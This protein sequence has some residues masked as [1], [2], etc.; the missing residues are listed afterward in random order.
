MSFARVYSAQVSFL[1]GQI[2]TVEVDLS[3][4]LHSFSIVGL[5]DKAVGESKDRISG[6]IKNSGFVSPKSKNQKIV[7]SLS[8]AGFKKEGPF[9]DLAMALAYLL[10]SGDI[11]FNP[12]NKLFLGELGLDGVLRGIR[13]TLLLLEEAKKFGFEEIYLPVENETESYL[14]KGIKIFPVKNLKEVVA[15]VSGLK[16]KPNVLNDLQNEKE[17]N[18]DEEI[19]KPKIRVDDVDFADIKGQE[20][21]KRG[22]EIASAGKHNVSMI[23]PPGT[24]KTMLAKAFTGILPALLDSEILEVTGIHSVAGILHGEIVLFPPFRTPHHTSSYSSLIGGGSYPKPGEITLAH[25]GVLFLDEFLEFD[26]RAIEALR[27]PLEENFISISRGKGTVI[28]PCNFILITAMNPCPCGNLGQ[29]NFKKCIC[30]AQDIARYKR[31]LSGPVMDRIDLWLSVGNIDFNKDNNLDKFKQE[32]SEEIKK[33]ILEA[34][35]IQIERFKNSER[36]I[37]TNSEMNAKDIEIY[38][39]LS[40]EAEDILRKSAEKLGFSMRSYHR[41]IKVARTIADLDKSDDIKINHIL[42]AIQYKGNS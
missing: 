22:L 31:K 23:G 41:V 17:K 32:S 11:K 25:R 2:V 18:K 24:G 4:G 19:F 6:A 8:P 34:R 37:Y 9:F 28:F 35:E 20:N 7:I 27:Q 14:V 5:P 12:E 36:K 3:R 38:S 33:R 21:A 40:K 10:A 1:K 26:K 30:Q 39:K 42:E 29:D 15:Y 13:G 16:N